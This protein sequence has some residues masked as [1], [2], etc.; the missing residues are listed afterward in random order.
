MVSKENLISIVIAVYNAEKYLDKCLSSV[1]RQ[2]FANIEILLIDDGSIDASLDICLKWSKSDSRV[3][4]WHQNNSGVSNAR[5]KGIELAKGDYIVFVDADDY[6]EQTYIQNL[7][8]KRNMA[9]IVISG[10]NRVSEYQE[11]I[12]LGREGFLKREEMFFNMLCTNI[13][14]GA[15]WNKIFKKKILMEHHISFDENIDVGEDMLFVTEYLQHCASYYYINKALYSYYNNKESV[16][17]NAYTNREIGEK[18]FSCL[19][20]VEKL[21]LLTIKESRKIKTYIGY[22][23]ARSSIRLLF[24][25]ILGNTSDSILFKKIKHNCQRNWLSHMKTT[26]GTLLEKVACIAVCCSPH[27]VYWGGRFL[28]N[29]RLLITDKYIK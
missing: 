17:H 15:C 11:P 26:S 6:V 3:I 14:T 8:E 24:Q 21:K 7:Y 1:A 19:E 12:L 25:M 13:V 27:F 18:D 16:M 10:Y 4:V 2:T 23:V 28:I 9:D 29:R 22:R 20:S 5:N